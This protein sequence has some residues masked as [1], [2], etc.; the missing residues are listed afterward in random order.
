[1]VTKTPAELEAGNA[2]DTSVVHASQND[3]TNFSRKHNERDISRLQSAIFDYVES[4][5]SYDVGDLVIF[6]DNTYLCITPT[7]GT[8][9]PA[10]WQ[11][12]SKAMIGIFTMSY[13]THNITLDQFF[14]VNGGVQTSSANFLR[15]AVPLAI[16]VKLDM[17]RVSFNIFNAT[18]PLF[19]NL[20]IGDETGGNLQQGNLSVEVDSAGSF[21][22]DV[23]FDNV[24]AG[25]TIAWKV[26]GTNSNGNNFFLGSSC[27][28]SEQ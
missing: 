12:Q 8:F 17:A 18:M 13:N 6:E 25:Q 15:R 28:V 14:A 1:M 5:K 2:T 22:D 11:N 16:D 27:R 3:D 21:V 10:D 7:S 23:N 20:Y 4:S 9:N 19:V 24:N 26:E